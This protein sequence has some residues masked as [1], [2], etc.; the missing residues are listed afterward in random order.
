MITGMRDHVG[1]IVGCEIHRLLRSDKTSRAKHIGD[2]E[3]VKPA[4]CRLM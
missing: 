4:V 2:D 3:S 1:F